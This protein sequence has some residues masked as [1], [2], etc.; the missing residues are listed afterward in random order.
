MRKLFAVLTLASLFFATP[1]AVA[2]SKPSAKD[3]IACIKAVKNGGRCNLP[4]FDPATGK[5]LKGPVGK[6]AKKTAA[7][8]GQGQRIEISIAE[9]EIRLWDGRRVVAEYA[10]STGTSSHPT[11]R[12]NYKILSKETNHWSR[13]YGVWMP[14]AMRIVGGIFIHQNPVTTDGRTIGV[15]ALGNPAS[16][17]CIRV[18]PGNAKSV[19]NFARVG[20]PVWI[21]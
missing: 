15:K 7:P 3:R 4:G 18:G 8:S 2:A 1:S 12:G 5:K 21:H 14:Y 6:V 20:T 17:G 11:P 16:H 9:Q 13:S 19:Y 10:V